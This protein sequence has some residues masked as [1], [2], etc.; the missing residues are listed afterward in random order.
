[1]KQIKVFI[2]SLPFM[3]SVFGCSHEELMNSSDDGKTG[4]IREVEVELSLGVNSG[5]QLSTRS[6]ENVRENYV[7]TRAKD[8]DL[9]RELTSDASAQKIN[10]M[11]IYVFRSKEEGGKYEFYIPEG[12]QDK[13]HYFVSSTGVFNNKTPYYSNEHD[14]G[15]NH[16]ITLKPKLE[17]G[18]YYKF[19]AIGRDDRYANI[20][21]MGDYQHQW[22]YKSLQD[23]DFKDKTLDDVSMSGIVLQNT[24]S[25]STLRCTELFT[26][27][28]RENDLENGKEEAIF[29]GDGDMFQQRN[30]I[31]RRAVA[32]LIMYVKN[33]PLSVVDNDGFPGALFKPSYV[34]IKANAASKYVNLVNR[35]M[36][37]ITKPKDYKTLSEGMVY[38]AVID[39]TTNEWEEDTEKGIFT[40]PANSE[41]GWPEN[42]Y[43]VSNYLM[44]TSEDCIEYMDGTIWDDEVVTF[45]LHYSA[46][47]DIDQFNCYQKIK[48]K[49]GNNAPTCFCPIK[50][51]YIYRLSKGNDPYPLTPDKEGDENIV[52]TVYPD[53]ENVSDLEWK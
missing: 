30:I 11:R 14:G 29:V 43:M 47:V 19:L 4:K 21:N 2:L 42:S 3:L 5:L 48:V 53:W 46:M 33:I 27:L 8:E 13:D 24:R 12:L 39:L 36:P 26:G 41:K 20:Y 25:G 49:L 52:I 38:V 15:E 1:M 16:I 44:P 40:R 9:P 7:Q 45:I 22:G 17:E 31:L 10:D 51:N 28:M 18:Y 35:E 23:P 32:G 37:K 6:V 34:A 50:A